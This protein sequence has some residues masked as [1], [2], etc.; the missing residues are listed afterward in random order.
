MLGVGRWAYS[1]YSFHNRAKL[2]H[3]V[4][5][6]ERIDLRQ[7]LAQLVRKPLRHT[8]AHDQFLIWSLAK[9]AL[10]MRIENRIDRFLLGRIDER[11]RVHDQHVGFL[12]ARCDFHSA[13]QNTPEHDFG[14]DQVFGATETDHAHFRA[15]H[16]MTVDET[17]T[18]RFASASP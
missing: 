18:R 8:A 11:A 14:V 9:S 15:L 10:L 16:P 7:L 3:L 4:Q 1:E 17:L 5:S 12:R 13:L 2:T 6:N